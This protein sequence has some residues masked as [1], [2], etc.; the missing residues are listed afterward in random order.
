V[1]PSDTG[2]GFFFLFQEGLERENLG[3]QRMSGTPG[4]QVL[5]HHLQG[6]ANPLGTGKTQQAADKEPKS[7]RSAKGGGEGYSRKQPPL[8]T[9]K[10]TKGPSFQKTTLHTHKTEKRLWT[11]KQER[12]TF[13]QVPTSNSTKARGPPPQE[14][15]YKIQT[16]RK[17]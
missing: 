14:Q 9:Q 12:F 4:N 13:N 2:P 17:T 3:G 15:N 6:G 10:K 16:T 8:R 11:E 7:A 5:E 1:G